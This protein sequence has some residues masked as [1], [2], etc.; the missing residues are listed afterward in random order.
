MKLD[1]PYLDGRSVRAA[2]KMHS[3][4]DADTGET[5]GYLYSRQGGPSWAI[6]LFADKFEGKYKTWE[7]CVAFAEGV[8]QVLSIMV[9]ALSTHRPE[10]IIRESKTDAA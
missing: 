2:C 8:E 3:V 6:S 5:V 10:N 9:D 4:K 1:V 7:E